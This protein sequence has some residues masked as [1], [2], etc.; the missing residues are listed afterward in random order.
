MTKKK[1][2]KQKRQQIEGTTNCQT[3]Y[4]QLG[5]TLYPTC[6]GQKLDK[7]HSDGFLGICISP[8][9]LKENTFFPIEQN[10]GGLS[11]FCF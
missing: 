11:C 7:W 5:E 3:P 4:T 9:P 6:D 10:S 2:K 8:L 1:E